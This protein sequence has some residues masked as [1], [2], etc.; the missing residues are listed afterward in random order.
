MLEISVVLAGDLSSSR[1]ESNFCLLVLL[2][3][4]SSTRTKSAVVDKKAAPVN[5]W[6][7]RENRPVGAA[8]ALPE[9]R[10]CLFSNIELP[11]DKR[12]AAMLQK[13][14]IHYICG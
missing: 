10:T 1:C 7:A 3:P 14:P 8:V 6:E 13:K 5:E 2:V 12:I 11:T 4:L 9:V